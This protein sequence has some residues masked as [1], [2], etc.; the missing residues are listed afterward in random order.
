MISAHRQGGGSARL[1]RKRRGYHRGRR[2][3][4]GR[5]A[6]A[7]P[8]PGPDRTGAL[9]LEEWVSATR[10]ANAAG[11][12]TTTAKGAIPAMP[13]SAAIQ[14]CVQLWT[15][16]LFTPDTFRILFCLLS[17]YVRARCRCIC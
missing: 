7:D 11:G 17:T 12:L 6:C 1:S 3:L 15:A 14:A 10:V 5:P 9:T 13:D 8:R 4:L 2:R 16:V